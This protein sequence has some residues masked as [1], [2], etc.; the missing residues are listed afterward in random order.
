MFP[1]GKTT[2][3][4]YDL[5]GHK[6]KVNHPDAGE[7]TCTYDAAGNL[8]TKLTAELKKTIS[9]KA[10]I[11]YTYDYER[12]SEVIYPKNLFNRVTYTYGKPGG[13]STTARAGS[14]WWRTPRAARPTTTATRARW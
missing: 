8:L 10:A 7:V 6:L 9:D 5:L 2:A 14:C 4:E 11:T 13:P 1:N 12:L 3:Y